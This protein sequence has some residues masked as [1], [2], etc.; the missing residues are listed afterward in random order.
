MTNLSKGYWGAL[1]GPGADGVFNEGFTK[2]RHFLIKYGISPPGPPE[3]GG[4]AILLV[5]RI[6]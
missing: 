1:P 2:K 6:T 3:K 4:K 5:P